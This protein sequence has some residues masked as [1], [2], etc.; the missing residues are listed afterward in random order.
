MKWTLQ[1]T[2]TKL[3]HTSIGLA[4]LLG[5][6][7]CSNSPYPTEVD[8]NIQS[9]QSGSKKLSFMLLA[10]KNQINSSPKKI[11]IKI[12]SIKNITNSSQ[13]QSDFAYIASTLLTE[14]QSTAKLSS[15]LQCPDEVVTVFEENYNFDIYRLNGVL[16]SSDKK[17]SQRESFD[18]KISASALDTSLFGGFEQDNEFETTQIEAALFLTGR[19]GESKSGLVINNYVKTGRST[20]NIDYYYLIGGTGQERSR[21]WSKSQGLQ[22]SANMLIKYSLIELIGRLYDFDYDRTEALYYQTAHSHIEPVRYS[23]QDFDAFI[24][25]L[26]LP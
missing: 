21:S 19:F 1:L 26:E 3:K 5:L 11:F 2:V 7:G 9:Y 15:C 12:S 20:N 18:T 4:F 16:A 14:L 22:Y 25:E 23:E 10:L 13:L 6:C 8:K 24:Q 17:N